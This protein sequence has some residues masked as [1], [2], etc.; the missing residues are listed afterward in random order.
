MVSRFHEKTGDLLVHLLQLL[1]L[2]RMVKVAS[3]QHKQT[4]KRLCYGIEDGKLAGRRHYRIEQGRSHQNR[5]A[6]VSRS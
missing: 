2:A 1:L 6:K 4:P 3:L 5:Y